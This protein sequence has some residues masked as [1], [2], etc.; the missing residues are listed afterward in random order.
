MAAK[1]PGR[2]STK[3]TRA[4]STLKRRPPGR[5]ASTR[6]HAETSTRKAKTPPPAPPVFVLVKSFDMTYYGKRVFLRRPTVGR[7]MGVDTTAEQAQALQWSEKSGAYKFL[8][9]NAERLKA[10]GFAVVQIAGAA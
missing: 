9:R 3:L 6:P 1:R 10:H 7:M 4:A 5:V 2:M 8:K